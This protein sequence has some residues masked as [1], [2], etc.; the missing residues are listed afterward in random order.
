MGLD[1]PQGEVYG[2][3]ARNRW[4]LE[5]L[6]FSEGKIYHNGKEVYGL[7]ADAIETI[8][9]CFKGLRENRSTEDSILAEIL[10]KAIAEGEQP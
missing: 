10:T 7:T 6:L 2:T 8:R 4:L 5:S 9:R 3:S 1:F